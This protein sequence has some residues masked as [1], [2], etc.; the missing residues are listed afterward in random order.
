MSLQ[1]RPG[2][3]GFYG[4]LPSVEQFICFSEFHLWRK[5]FI[6]LPLLLYLVNVFPITHSEASKVSSAKGCCFRDERSH[7][8]TVE[9]IRL[10][11]HKGIVYRSTA[12]YTQLGDA[13]AGIGFHRFQHIVSLIKKDFK[14]LFFFIF[15]HSFFFLSQ[16]Y[17]HL[18]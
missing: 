9:N 5:C 7:Y 4:T 11:L 10:K 15:L 8:F 17:T 1:I 12:I 18:P 3:G 16:E 14:R 13:D 2:Y 6:N